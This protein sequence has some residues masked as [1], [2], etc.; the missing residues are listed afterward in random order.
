MAGQ[1]SR[2]MDKDLQFLYDDCDNYENEISELYA[3]SEEI[4]F[5][6]NMENFE[7]LLKSKGQLLSFQNLT[8]LELY[9]IAADPENRMVILLFLQTIHCCVLPKLRCHSFVDQMTLINFPLYFAIK[10]GRLS[11]SVITMDASIVCC[12]RVYFYYSW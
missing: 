5:E 2:D 9:S 6:K 12:L 1:S 8:F 4:E 3:Y 11:T 10:Y 7:I